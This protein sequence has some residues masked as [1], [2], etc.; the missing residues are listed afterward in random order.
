MIAT[1]SSR[2]VLGLGIAALSA[3]LVIGGCG[4][5]K[6][7][8]GSASAATTLAANPGFAQAATV[9]GVAPEK[10]ETIA[11][12]AANDISTGRRQL[13]DLSTQERAALSAVYLY[14]KDRDRDR[15]RD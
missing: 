12:K 6:S 9:Q 13:K 2:A 8:A 14:M 10:F 4:G 1:L 11:I 7:E 3:A 15:D 5:N